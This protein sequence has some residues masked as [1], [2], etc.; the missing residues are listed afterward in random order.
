MDNVRANTELLR[1]N[2]FY[3]VV[4]AP[5]IH[6]GPTKARSLAVALAPGALS[7]RM[8]HLLVEH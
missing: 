4:A 2:L 5:M 7:G 6:P 1:S 8:R 3:S